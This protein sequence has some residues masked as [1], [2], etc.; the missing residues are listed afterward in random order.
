M[1]ASALVGAAFVSCG[2][3]L[4]VTMAVTSTKTVT[5]LQGAP[6]KAAA[7]RP[8]HA[9]QGDSVFARLPETISGTARVVLKGPPIQRS[10]TVTISAKRTVIS[11]SFYLRTTSPPVLRAQ[12]CR[13]GQARTKGLV[14]LDFGMLAYRPKRGGYGTIL[15]SDR[16]ASQRSITW[17]MKSFAR[18]YHEC[19][20]KWATA[21]IIVAR[22]T[23]NYRQN[24]P[25]TYT[26]GRLWAK[27]TAVFGSYLEHHGFDDHVTAAAADDV[28]P[29]WDR[30]FHRTRDF[31]RGYR[32]AHTG[33]L[34]YNYGSLDGGA[35]GIWTVGQAYFVAGGMRYARAVPEIYNHAMAQQ[36]AH[37]SRVSVERFGRP[38]Q[39]AGLMTQYW[40]G[41]GGFTAQQAH[42]ALVRELARHPKTRVRRLASVTNIGTQ[43]HS[44]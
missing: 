32:A 4:A 37:L 9:K 33:Y 16:F 40:K 28:E 43:R 10:Q 6:A 13:L 17:A 42:D 20:P 34:L 24:V 23:S 22:G 38:V 5:V 41:T 1:L 2:I 31:F 15:F 21:K 27:E 19:L 39:F 26:A 25:S 44:S 36:W 14:I 18:G 8:A 30:T 3:T 11:P 35:G 7:A 12:G 29:A